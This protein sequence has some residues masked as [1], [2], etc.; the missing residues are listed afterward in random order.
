[1]AIKKNN[2]LHVQVCRVKVVPITDV[3][4]VTMGSPSYMRQVNLKE[5][6]S[7]IDLYHTPGSAEFTEKWKDTEAGM[8]FEQILRIQFP[9]LDETNR[10]DLGMLERRG[11]LIG[12][13]IG[14]AGVK[15][16]LM[17]SPDNGAR[18]LSS[19]SAGSKT[20]GILLEFTCMAT[21]KAWWLAVD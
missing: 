13:S 5:G 16:L 14:E 11:M 21:Q 19:I 17:G 6:A 18:L 2:N 7:W 15:W 4:S 12:I 1:M 20:P 9:G 8:L 10:A 3:A